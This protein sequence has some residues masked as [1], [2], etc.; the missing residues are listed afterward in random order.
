MLARI[1]LNADIAD[2]VAPTLHPVEL[3]ALWLHARANNLRPAWI[4]RQVFDPKRKCPR[5]AGIP[6][7]C[8][9]AGRLL[10]ALSPDVAVAVLDI[11]IRLG[12]RESAQVALAADQR[13]AGA[14]V[15]EAF[16]A[17]WAALEAERHGDRVRPPGQAQPVV[18]GA[19]HESPAAGGRIPRW[20][21]V[22]AAL[23]ATLP[24]ADY[25]TWIAPLLLVHAEDAVAVIAT[26]NVFVRTEIEGR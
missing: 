24:D 26:P 11:A 16:A 7:A 25:A 23:K 1:S 22:K 13:T 4:A 21:R 10:A 6:A 19:D 2:A 9:E 14:E 5:M 18:A 15:A 17:T 20:I 12:D 3:W 8:E